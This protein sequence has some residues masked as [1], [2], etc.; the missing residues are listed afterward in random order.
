MAKKA[1]KKKAKK[2]AGAGKP[3]EKSI[4]VS[5]ATIMKI[6]GAVIHEGHEEE[7]LRKTKGMSVRVGFKT[8]DRVKRFFKP[9][10]EA[11]NLEFRTLAASVA[12]T[13][14][15]ICDDFECPHIHH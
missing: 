4:P 15:E 14:Q 10:R 7:F 12:R 9:H 1:K 11:A 13:R 2:R 5:V 8:V 3:R 6:F